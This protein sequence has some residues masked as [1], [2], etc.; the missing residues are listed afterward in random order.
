MIASVLQPPSAPPVDVDD[1]RRRA[2]RLAGRTLGELAAGADLPLPADLVRSKGFVGQLLE[3]WLGAQAGSR[4]QPDFA[5]L[6]IELKSLPIDRVGRPRQS[7]YVATVPL[8]DLDTVVWRTSSVCAKLRHVLWVP[9]EAERRVPLASR[10]VGQAFLWQPTVEE[11][12]LLR[13]DWEL[14][15]E[16]IRAGELSAI[17]GRDGAVLQVRPKARDSE[18]VAV[19]ELPYRRSMLTGPRGFYL[20]PA[21]TRYLIQRYFHQVDPG[22]AVDELMRRTC[23]ATSEG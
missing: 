7:T 14:H 13:A 3:V 22:A 15:V 16:R 4:P 21:F 19:A 18:V 5:H 12:Q 20:R 8:R 9:I 6:G 2:R 17:C 23:P 11:E 1:L 10:I